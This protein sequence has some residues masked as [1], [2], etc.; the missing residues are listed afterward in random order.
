MIGI[1][2]S[3]PYS[4]NQ[5]YFKTVVL[6]SNVTTNIG[7]LKIQYLGCDFGG[8]VGEISLPGLMGTGEEPY[9]PEE[10]YVDLL[11]RVEGED[12]KK[13]RVI[14]NFNSF[15]RGR[16][17]IIWSPLLIDYGLGDYYIT[18]NP[19][20]LSDLYL[21]YGKI[22]NN[23]LANASSPTEYILYSHILMF[24]AMGMGLN[25]TV[26]LN[27]SAYWSEDEASL[28]NGIIISYKYVPFIKFIWLSSFFFIVGEVIVLIS[29]RSIFNEVVR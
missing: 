23:M 11:F 9:V 4:Y 15:L 13:L 27:R 14:F 5:E 7:N 1:L 20:G 25:S 24:L 6:E 10:V 17:S 28:Q 19:A 8:P 21:Y 2:L 26:F 29:R 12:I 3:G 16:G 22:I 18:I